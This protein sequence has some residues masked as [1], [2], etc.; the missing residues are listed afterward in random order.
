MNWLSESFAPKMQKIANLPWIA[1]LSSAMQKVI[2]FILTGSI[3]FLYNVLRSYIVLLPDLGVIADYSFGMLGLITAYMLTHQAMEKL[4]RTPYQINAALT[5]VSVFIIF[6]KPTVD[7]NGLFS[8]E[9]ARFGPTGIMVGLIAGIFVTLVFDLFGR[10]NF[11]KESNAPDFVVIWLNN[12]IPMLLIL[13][14]AGLLTFDFGIDIFQVIVGI[15]TPIQSFGQTLPGFLLLCFIPTFL[16]SMGIS[17]WLWGAVATPIFLAGIAANI[18]AV[19]QGL[20]AMN[21]S[22]G[23]TVYTAALTTM[24]GVGATLGLNIL[25]LRSKSRDLSTIGKITIVPSFFNINEP[26]M[27]SAPVVMNPM[28][29]LPLWINGITGPL[30]VWIVMR[31]GWLN[32]PHQMIQVG[33]I[34]SPFSTFMITQDWRSFIVYALMFVVYILTWYPF[35]KVYE[36]QRVE[37]ERMEDQLEDELESQPALS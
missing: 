17:T 33:Q 20:P 34:P 30:I 1:A 37:Q 23:E 6:I 9:F 19:K 5:S 10:L 27:F 15:F 11:M 29:M 14:I 25:M 16:Y 24:G 18:E 2:P 8:V 31:L 21:I 35:F 26:L 12:I 22:T 3:I 32:I 36:Q 4:N 13:G 7:T 28:L